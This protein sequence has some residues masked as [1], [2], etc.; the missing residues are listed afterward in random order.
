MCK[1]YNEAVFQEQIAV[2]NSLSLIG[3][4]SKEIFVSDNLL[5][6]KSINYILLNK[7]TKMEKVSHNRRSARCKYMQSKIL[8]VIQDRNCNTVTRVS[9]TKRS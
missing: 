8:P 6:V 2:K 9:R 5:L 4:F 3:E 7:Q 1:M